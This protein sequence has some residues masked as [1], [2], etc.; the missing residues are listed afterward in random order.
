MDD[1]G[2][3]EESHTHHC[4]IELHNVYFGYGIASEQS[5]TGLWRGCADPALF[6]LSRLFAEAVPFCLPASES[7]TVKE[8]GKYLWKVT[9]CR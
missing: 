4:K 2:S 7:M 1:A 6:G 3:D 9:V 5:R 8:K